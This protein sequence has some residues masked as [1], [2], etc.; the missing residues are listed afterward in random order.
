MGVVLRQVALIALITEPPELARVVAVIEEELREG[1]DAPEGVAGG[2]ERTVV[3]AVDEDHRNV[4][5]AADSG[6]EAN[7]RLAEIE[8]LDHWKVVWKRRADLEVLAWRRSA[9]RF[10]GA[11]LQQHRDDGRNAK[12]F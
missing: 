7:Y 11:K 4:V 1:L 6:A 5:D 3:V 10:S 8:V 12:I 9:R 2:R